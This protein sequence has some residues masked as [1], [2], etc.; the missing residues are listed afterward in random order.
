MQTFTSMILP[1]F[2]ND[3]VSCCFLGV[4]PQFNDLA[5]TVLLT[6]NKDGSWYDHTEEMINEFIDEQNIRNLFKSKIDYG[7]WKKK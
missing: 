1:T 3:P 2:N 4:Y 7:K 6:K 5:I